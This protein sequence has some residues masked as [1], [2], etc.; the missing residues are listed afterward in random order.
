MGFLSQWFGKR[1]SPAPEFISVTRVDE[2]YAY[3]QSRTC[4][5]GGRWKPVQQ[6]V[7]QV[8]G[9]PAHFKL[10]T[11]EVVCMQCHTP[12]VFRFKVDTS[13]PAYMQELM[14]MEKELLGKE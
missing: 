5:C 12:G 13:H 6:S 11:L 9:A 14:E 1:E 3:I 7:G 8:P 4:K 10:D 2:E